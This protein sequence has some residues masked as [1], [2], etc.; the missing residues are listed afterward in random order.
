MRLTESTINCRESNLSVSR[1]QRGP[2][3]GVMQKLRLFFAAFAVAGITAA[4]AGFAWAQECSA[5]GDA[6]KP[7]IQHLNQLKNRT[8]FPAQLR[9]MQVAEILA[10]PDSEDEGLE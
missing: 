6:T 7:A 5:E 8:D 2:E 4:T 9:E 3:G 1:C 10:R